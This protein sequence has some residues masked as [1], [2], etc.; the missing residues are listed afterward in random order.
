MMDLDEDVRVSRGE[1]LTW[2]AENLEFICERNSI[3]AGETP[4]AVE[5]GV[6]VLDSDGDVT[7]DAPD[8]ERLDQL[9]PS[10]ELS[11]GTGKIIYDAIYEDALADPD[12][13]E[14]EGG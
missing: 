2:I 9:I 10:A 11:N 8:I 1:L 5:N 4:V 12:K 6:G 7:I 13:W 3:I 14:E